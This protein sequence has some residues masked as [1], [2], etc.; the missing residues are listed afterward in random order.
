MEI[1]KRQ[2]EYNKIVISSGH[3][4]L[5]RGASGIL[6]EVNEAR[7]VVEATAAKLRNGELGNNFDDVQRLRMRI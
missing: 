3:G 1:R 5:V 7:R 4:K 6:D 2:N